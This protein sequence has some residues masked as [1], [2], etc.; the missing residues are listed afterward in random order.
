M[1]T[2]HWPTFQVEH[3][4]LISGDLRKVGN[5]CEFPQELGEQ[6]QT[7]PA[8]SFVFGH[9][10]DFVEEAINGLAKARDL[11]E[12]AVVVACLLFFLHAACCFP[13]SVEQFAFG[14][15]FEEFSVNSAAVFQVGLLEN[16]ADAL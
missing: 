2:D 12:R 6:C 11:I 14:V 8:Y 9:D 13:T 3:S 15:V 4:L 16:L 1:P 10:H 5:S 7:I